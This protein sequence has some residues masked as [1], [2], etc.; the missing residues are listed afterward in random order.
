MASMSTQAPA[1]THSGTLRP[2]TAWWMLSVL[3]IFNIL[4]YLD[5]L[6]LTMLVVPIKGELGI[7]DFQ[8]SIIL[9][10]AFAVCYALFG[11]FIGWGVDRYSR[12]WIIFG[13]VMIWSIATVMSG[14]VARSYEMLLFFRILCGIG[15]ATLGPAVVSLLADAFSR[16]KMTTALSVYQSAAKIGA[17]A[18]MAFGGIA[19]A[20]STTYLL[21]HDV[22]GIHQPW[23]LVLAMAGAPGVILAFLVFT[24]PEP[25]RALSAQTKV[26]APKGLLGKTLKDHWQLWLTL[27]IGFCSLSILGFALSGWLPTYFDRRFN[28]TPIQ[29]GPGLS[30]TNLA[31]AA[32]M[33][34]NG[35]IVD[36]LYRKGIADIHLRF[37][38]WLIIAMSPAFIALTFVHNPYVVLGCY[39]LVQFVTLPFF[40]Y[41]SAVIVLVAPAAARGQV[42]GI[43]L[44]AFT[45][46][47][48]GLGPMLVGMITDYVLHDENMIGESLAIVTIGGMVTAILMLQLALPYFRRAMQQSHS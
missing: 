38:K 17:A 25:R 5:R 35:W 27:L 48:Q 46:F 7:S 45:V 6:I 21:E 34:V 33:V 10:P 23:H 42:T 39:A 11:L 30:L 24:F 44:G 8:M 31:S 18:A 13:G 37:Y 16:D 41:A 9:G 47:G 4:D 40:V 19:M 28:W 43:F 29:Y 1:T 22:W 12:R 14:L 32:S 2:M 36:R 26:A 15:Q 20:F 3:F